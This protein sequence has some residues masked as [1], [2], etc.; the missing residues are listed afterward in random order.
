MYPHLGDADKLLEIRQE[1]PNARHCELLE[2]QANC[3]LQCP[4]NPRTFADA[5]EDLLE[6]WADDCN[7][8]AIMLADVN[9]GI[10]YSAS[11]ITAVQRNLM[12]RAKQ[13]VEDAEEDVRL[14]KTDWRDLGEEE[15]LEKMEL[16]KRRGLHHHDEGG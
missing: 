15:R 1:T 5:D 14:S 11:E 13:A 16:I 6:D 2:G 7:R 8:A 4:K 10:T 3:C 9:S 12:I